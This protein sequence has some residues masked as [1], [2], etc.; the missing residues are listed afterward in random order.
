MTT[1]LLDNFLYPRSRFYGKLTPAQQDFNA[2]LQD[3]AQR[4]SMVCALGTGGTLSPEET[5]QQVSRLWKQ[6]EQNRY[7]AEHDQAC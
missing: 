3:F 7:Y 6:L 4:V 2:S 1:A 5:Y